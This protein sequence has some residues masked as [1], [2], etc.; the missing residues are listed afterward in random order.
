LLVLGFSLALLPPLARADEPLRYRVE[1]GDT[2]I[3]VAERHLEDPS[4]WPAVARLNGVSQPRRLQPGTVL[5]LSAHLLKGDEKPVSVLYVRG[6]VRRLHAAGNPGAAVHLGDTL[7]EGDLLQVGADSYASLRLQDGSQL[8]VQAGSQVRVQRSREVPQSRR[9]R[10][11]IGLEQG[12]VDTQVAPQRPG[13]RFD[14]RTPL[15]VAGVR[16]TRFGVSLN[17]DGSQALSDV[18]EGQVA[19]EVLSSGQSSAV[20]AGQG[21]VVR[22]G[23]ARPLVRSLLAAPLLSLDAAQER[24]PFVLPIEPVP[25]AV[26]YRVQIAEDEALT[27]VRFSRE[28]AVL[29][30]MVPELADGRYTLVARAVD[31]DG[32]MGAETRRPLRVKTQPVPPLA[33]G[34]QPEQVLPA[35]PV[36]LVCT[37]VPGAVAYRWLVTR[38]SAAH[39]D[40]ATTPSTV[41]DERRTGPCRLALDAS[42]PGHYHWRVA[43]V[44]NDATGQ[45]DTGPLG[46]VSRFRT[47]PVPAPPEPAIEVGDQVR[48]H[49][50]GAPGTRFEVELAADIAFTR[51]VQRHELDTSEVSLPMPSWCQPY[52]VRLRS[53]TPDGLRS[54]FSPPRLL[55]TRPAVCAG[56]GSAVRDG[57]GA[58]LGI[59][60]R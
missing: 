5:S 38:S 44:V 32:L 50:E 10:T 19:V 22:Q 3:G 34:P 20:A 6:D 18:V 53:I 12:R 59:E 42:E 2:L 39:A 43:T 37:E 8:H 25:G 27:R 11:S 21:A 55:N 15:A 48:I 52:H 41:F 14:V 30:V 4:Q 24:L 35:G 7:Q 46:D 1:S 29:P 56:D 54:P 17:A 60:R 40:A 58:R 45:P 49:W 28:G 33:Q 57:G 13:S 47:A 26:A 9:L 16:G 51:E 23:R 31:A 36:E